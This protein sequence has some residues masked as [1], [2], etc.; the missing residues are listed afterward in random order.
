MYR[1]QEIAYKLKMTQNGVRARAKKLSLFPEGLTGLSLWTEEQFEEISSYVPDRP[2]KN[3]YS[4]VKIN[5]IDFYLTHKHNTQVEI[6]DAMGLNPS[7]V[8]SVLNEY[9]IDNCI[10]VESK[11]NGY[12]L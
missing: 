1:T 6:A 11:I 7:R 8:N 9:L 5:I 12:A 10:I 4:K 3:K 2:F